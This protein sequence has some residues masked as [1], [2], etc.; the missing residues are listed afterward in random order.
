MTPLVRALLGAV[1]GAV[2]TLVLH[3]LTRPFFLNALRADKP[4]AAYQAFAMARG[5]ERLPPPASLVDAGL[6]LQLASER[7]DKRDVLR[8]E[9]I[10]SVLRIA[11]RAAEKE[12]DNAFWRQMEAVLLAADGRMD[13]ARAAWRRAANLAVWQDHQSDR[14]RQEVESL[15]RRYG[16]SQAWHAGLGYRMR[17]DAPSRVI[18]RYARALLAQAPLEDPEGLRDRFAIHVNG[19]LLRRGARSIACGDVGADLVELASYPSDLA[20]LA[21]PRK[22]LLAQEEFLRALRREM[23]A[24]YAERAESIFRENDAWRAFTS[25][26]DPQEPKLFNLASVATASAPGVLLVV[27]LVGAAI[28]GLRWLFERSTDAQEFAPAAATLAAAIV[29]LMT[30]RLT[31]YPLLAVATGLCVLFLAVGPRVRRRGRPRELGPLFD[32]VVGALALLFLLSLFGGLLVGTYPS[33]VLLPLLP[34]PPEFYN[35]PTV[36]FGF[37]VLSIALLCLVS[38]MWALVHRFG[39]PSVLS[40]AVRKFG[41]FV[42]A[43]G[44]GLAILITPAAFLLDRQL[45]ETHLRLLGNEPVYYLF[46]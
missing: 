4:A 20:H 16:A 41:G 3:P 36:Y 39:T 13:D 29:A 45:Q 42:A 40:L 8:P 14:L 33:R 18:E 12:P 9:E 28:L 31:W 19:H 43:V 37:A 11:R 17:S 26:R 23:G 30:Y 5:G 22:L 21:T 27:A 24:P 6:W 10:D 34:I 35:P 44:L 7:L 46:R 15:A 38:P 25:R 2:L 1:L 32:F